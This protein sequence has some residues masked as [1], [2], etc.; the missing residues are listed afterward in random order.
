M[1]GIDQGLSP[2]ECVHHPRWHDQL[3]GQTLFEVRL[4]ADHDCIISENAC[5]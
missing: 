1:D 5:L 3:S 2:E 4:C